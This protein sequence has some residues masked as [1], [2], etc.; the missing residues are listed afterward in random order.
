MTVNDF[1]NAHSLVDWLRGIQSDRNWE[2]LLESIDGSHP[3]KSIESGI[4][5]TECI[6]K[7]GV[8]EG[9]DMALDMIKYMGKPNLPDEPLE[10]TFEDPNKK[11]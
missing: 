8:I 7:L 5:E 3:R 10:P 2:M 4:T 11:D 9:F 1:K 6:R